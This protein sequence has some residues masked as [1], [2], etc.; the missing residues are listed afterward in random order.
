MPE[1]TDKITMC[2]QI[3]KEM[4]INNA[5]GNNGNNGNKANGGLQTMPLITILT[6]NSKQKA[7]D[8]KE[9]SNFKWTGRHTAGHHNI[10]M[11]AVIMAGEEAGAAGDRKIVTRF[12]SNG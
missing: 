10:A 1:I 5:T 12:K 7:G 11:E 6:V 3:G 2:K 9:H 4:F 8:N